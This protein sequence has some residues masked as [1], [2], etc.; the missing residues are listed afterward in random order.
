MLLVRA[1]VCR[2]G[3]LQH[4]RYADLDLEK[5]SITLRDTKYRGETRTV[6]FLTVT[7]WFLAVL[8]TS[9]KASGQSVY[10][11]LALHEKW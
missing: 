7:K 9:W 3:E 2:P 8:K 6:P 5:Q 10:F 4:A 11:F 1:L